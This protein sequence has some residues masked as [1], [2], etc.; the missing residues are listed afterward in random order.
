MPRLPVSAD[1][2]TKRQRAM[3]DFIIT[4]KLSNDGNPPT[5]RE[6]GEAVG[7]SSVGVVHYNLM[8]L[9]LLGFIR[10]SDHNK[11]SKRICVV[12]GQWSFTPSSHLSTITSTKTSTEPKVSADLV[13]LDYQDSSGRV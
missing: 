12:G 11:M 4:F 9:E 7:I 2:L 8:R 1:P 13:K 3:L 5:H 6:I 10:M